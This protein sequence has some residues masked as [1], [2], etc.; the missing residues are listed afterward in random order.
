MQ[1]ITLLAKIGSGYSAIQ[2]EVAKL[3]T[4]VSV[5]IA[6]GKVW[7][8]FVFNKP[9][10]QHHPRLNKWASFTV[11]EGDGGRSYLFFHDTSGARP[12]DGIVGKIDDLAFEDAVRYAGLELTEAKTLADYEGRKSSR[13]APAATDLV[14]V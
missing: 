2:D 5:N 9:A 1:E 8:T 13:W 4:T 6:G 12:N 7:V 3:N 11:S 14:S 10:W